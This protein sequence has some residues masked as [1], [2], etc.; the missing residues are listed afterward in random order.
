MNKQNVGLDNKKYGHN[1]IYYW[2]SFIL[3]CKKFI[4]PIINVQ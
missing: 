3:I 2:M 4:R 1:Y